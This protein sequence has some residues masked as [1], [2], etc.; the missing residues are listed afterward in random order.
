MEA[1]WF[2]QTAGCCLGLFGKPLWFHLHVWEGRPICPPPSL[3]PEALLRNT[4]C[5]AR[6][7]TS[8][9]VQKSLPWGLEG[10]GWFSPFSCL[11][12]TLGGD[13]QA[14]SHKTCDSSCCLWAKPGDRVPGIP[15]GRESILSRSPQDLSS[16]KLPVVVVASSP[17]QG[18]LPFKSVDSTKGFLVGHL[19][20]G[21]SVTM[22]Y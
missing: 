21:A 5:A 4:H 8:C 1:A 20:P 2:P 17:F 13:G 3:I 10:Q 19:L 6:P 12:N 14:P 16:E 7:A 22:F 9:F 15:G 11:R 18:S